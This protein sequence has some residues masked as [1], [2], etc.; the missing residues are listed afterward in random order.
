[1]S[2][3]DLVSP[4]S[5]VFNKSSFAYATHTFDLTEIEGEVVALCMAQFEEDEDLNKAKVDVIVAISMETG[6]LIPTLGGKPY[7]S[8]WEELGTT[9][10]N[11]SD[12]VYKVFL[13]YFFVYW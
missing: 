4:I 10:T 5:A 11:P 7:F 9:S 3:V 1:M 2:D 12:S 6:K 8:F 13:S